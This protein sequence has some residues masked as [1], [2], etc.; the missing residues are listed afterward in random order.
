MFSSP[1][2]CL[3]VRQQDYAKTTQPIFTKFDRQVERGHREKS[4]YFGGNPGHVTLGLGG[5][6]D[7]R[8]A[9]ETISVTQRFFNSNKFFDIGGLGHVCALLS[10]ILVFFINKNPFLTLDIILT[11]FN[12]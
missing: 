10:A 6:G 2:V 9:R 11:L 5:W 12:F 8:A 4:M 3:F 7:R 1:T